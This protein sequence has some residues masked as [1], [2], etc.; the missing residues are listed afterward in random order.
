MM[1]NLTN[2]TLNMCNKNELIY[3]I[4]KNNS[5]HLRTKAYNLYIVRLELLIKIVKLDII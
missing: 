1:C 2:Q 4:R 5:V 3:F